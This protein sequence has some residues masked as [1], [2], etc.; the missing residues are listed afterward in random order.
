MKQEATIIFSLI[1]KNDYFNVRHVLLCT[2]LVNINIKFKEIN[3]FDEFETK[4]IVV[5]DTRQNLVWVKEALNTYGQSSLI[6]RSETGFA[7]KYNIHE[8]RSYPL[9]YLVK[10][11]EEYA[12]TQLLWTKSVE[13]NQ[14]YSLID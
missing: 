12:K 8:L 1:G 2:R 9:G 6:F 10:T 3:M 11:S 5:P 4:G 13:N 14:Y 7:Q